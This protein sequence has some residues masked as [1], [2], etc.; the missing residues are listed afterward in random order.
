M[1]GIE[2][3]FYGNNFIAD[4]NHL[5]WHMYGKYDIELVNKLCKCDEKEHSVRQFNY[6]GNGNCYSHHMQMVASLFLHIIPLFSDSNCSKRYFVAF[7][8]AVF[9]IFVVFIPKTLDDKRKKTY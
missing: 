6:M 7:F 9:L 4:K 3:K 1:N 8:V 5:F 2:W